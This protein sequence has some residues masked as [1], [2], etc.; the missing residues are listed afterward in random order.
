MRLLWN[1]QPNNKQMLFRLMRRRGEGGRPGIKIGH[2]RNFPGGPVIK[3]PIFHCREYE[4]DP[5][6]GVKIPEASWQK[7]KKHKTS[8]ILTNSINFFNGPHQ[9]KNL[10]KNTICH[11]KIC[12]HSRFSSRNYTKFVA[13]FKFV[14]L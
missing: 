5:G 2:F 14:L 13:V 3:T 10:K 8:N 11:F 7:K 6:W 12:K 4:F 1:E 9:K